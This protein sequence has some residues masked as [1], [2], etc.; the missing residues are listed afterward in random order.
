MKKYLWIVAALISS[1]CG[2]ALAG[3][4]INFHDPAPVPRPHYQFGIVACAV[5]VAV[6]DPCPTP[7]AGAKIEVQ[8]DDGWVYATANADGYALMNA[9]IPNSAVRISAAGFVTDSWSIEPPKIDG[10]NLSF[11]LVRDHV[12]PSQ[13]TLAELKAKLR[14]SLSV[15]LNLPY[16]ARPGQDSN[17]AWMAF[18]ELYGPADRTRM[19]AAYLSRGLTMTSIGPVTGNDC[20]HESFPN[21]GEP[22]GPGLLAGCLH[23][24]RV[25]SQA[26]WDAYLDGVQEQW[27]AGLMPCYHAKPDGWERADFAPLMDALDVL[28]RQPRAQRLIRCAIYAGWEPSGTKY[29]WPNRVYVQWVKRGAEVFPNA[30][31][32]IHL[33]ADLDAPTGGDD[34]QTFPKGEGNALSWV[35]VAP[36]I[37]F[38][39]DQVGGY[40]TGSTEVP[41]PTFM[42]ELC[43]HVQ[44]VR[45]G[46]AG[47][48]GWP[49][50]GA[51]GTR[52]LYILYEASAYADWW[53]NFAERYSWQ[54]GDA[55]MGC[56]A[57]GYGDGGTVPVRQ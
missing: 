5:P 40:V 8:H 25:P 35:N 26:E 4:T 14:G 15:R 13:F 19:R 44:R 27:D 49:T 50:A 12:D 46:F 2:G 51:D 41:D 39:A 47:G 48:Y 18:Y 31:R 52:L 23:N 7:I 55:A 57:D 32:G 54:I 53:R 20:Y 28:Y 11:T 42:S 36:F 21:I 56:G 10:Q 22:A 6:T 43:K 29:G 37:H 24:W 30:L 17:V 33:I 45:G 3:G 1:S 38:W 34:D 16:G 9:V